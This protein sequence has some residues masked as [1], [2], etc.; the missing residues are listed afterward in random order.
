MSRLP[1]LPLSQD[2]VVAALRKHNITV[3]LGVLEPWMARNTRF[4]VAWVS[5]INRVYIHL[6]IPPLT[7]C[8]GCQRWHIESRCTCPCIGKFGE[9]ARPPTGP[10]GRLGGDARRH[11]PWFREPSCCS[12]FSK[13]WS[14][15][16][17]V[18]LR[19]ENDNQCP[20]VDAAGEM[21]CEY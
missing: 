8:S 4:D 19:S 3:G 1:G 11:S 9:I 2:S 5:M 18:T 7:G 12:Y 16:S 21:N 10:H 6:L 20:S 13:T 15:R 17:R 14:C